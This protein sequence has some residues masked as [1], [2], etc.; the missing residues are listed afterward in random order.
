MEP[1]S[2]EEINELANCLIPLN[3]PLLER[4][5]Y[6]ARI[7]AEFVKRTTPLTRDSIGE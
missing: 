2:K 7:G 4:L 1:L 6:T 3:S 5:L